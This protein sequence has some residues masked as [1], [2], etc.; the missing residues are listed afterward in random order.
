M[1]AIATL[2]HM[3]V[4]TSCRLDSYAGRD[5]KAYFLHEA[6]LPS[7]RYLPTKGQGG[8]SGQSKSQESVKGGETVSCCVRGTQAVDWHSIPCKGS[9]EP[10]GCC[11]CIGIRA[12]TSKCWHH[13]DRASRNNRPRKGFSVQSCTSR[14]H[15]RQQKEAADLGP[16]R[17]SATKLSCHVEARTRPAPITQVSTCPAFPKNA[18]HSKICRGAGGTSLSFHSSVSNA[19]TISPPTAAFRDQTDCPHPL[20][21]TSA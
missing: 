3:H 12:C 21:S 10:A 8:K 4:E 19:N 9:H 13:I 11:M 5:I 6:C 7:G 20:L 1:C 14:R 15:L 18:W 16:R 17:I 2:A